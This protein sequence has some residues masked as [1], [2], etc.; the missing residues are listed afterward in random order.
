MKKNTRTIKGLR[1]SID[2]IKE[3]MFTGISNYKVNK[4]NKYKVKLPCLIEYNKDNG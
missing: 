1:N 4:K 3:D 2:K